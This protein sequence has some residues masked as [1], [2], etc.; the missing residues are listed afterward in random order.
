MI[1]LNKYT[2]FRRA[3]EVEQAC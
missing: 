3:E 1:T 2:H